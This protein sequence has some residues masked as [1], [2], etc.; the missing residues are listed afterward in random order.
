MTFFIMKKKFICTLFL[1]LI[2]C[3]PVH[4]ANPIFNMVSA[5]KS[6]KTLRQ[7]I[8]LRNTLTQML[9][10]VPTVSPNNPGAELSLSV[11]T[12]DSSPVFNL[13]VPYAPLDFQAKVLRTLSKLCTYLP[14]DKV[15]VKGEIKLGDK[16]L[17][18]PE[19]SYTL[20]DAHK[21]FLHLGHILAPSFRAV[22]VDPVGG[23]LSVSN[24]SQSKGVASQK[25]HV[26]DGNKLVDLVG[27]QGF[28]KKMFHKLTSDAAFLDNTLRYAYKSPLLEI[29][30]ET[31]HL[32]DADLQHLNQAMDRLE[33]TLESRPSSAETFILKIRP[34]S[35]TKHEKAEFLSI[36][37]L[38]LNPEVIRDLSTIL[39]FFPQNPARFILQSEE[40]NS[41]QINVSTPSTA[42]LPEILDAFYKAF[43]SWDKDL[44]HSFSTLT[45][46]LPE[47]SSKISLH[48]PDGTAALQLAQEIHNFLG[49]TG[50]E[51]I[52]FQ[53]F[54]NSTKSSIT[55]RGDYQGTFKNLVRG[56][57][58]M[59]HSR[60]SDLLSSPPNIPG[61]FMVSL[62]D[63]EGHAHFSST[64]DNTHEVRDLVHAKGWDRVKKTAA[65][66]W[67]KIKNVFKEKGEDTPPIGENSEDL[68]Q[69]L[70]R[71]E[72][73]HQGAAPMDVNT[74]YHYPEEG[75][76]QEEDEA[77]GSTETADEDQKKA[78]LEMLLRRYI[79]HGENPAAHDQHQKED[80]HAATKD[81][82]QALLKVLLQGNVAHHEAPPSS[83]I[84]STDPD[85][86]YEY[87]S[88][89]INYEYPPEEDPDAEDQIHLPNTL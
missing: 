28:F 47:H 3:G 80:N 25:F 89:D 63:D 35:R 29:D 62:I 50:T 8:E 44:D 88:E 2:I 4:A 14:H 79:S 20:S 86:N 10:T 41:T 36:Q 59:L 87:P 75:L 6:P 82:N 61:T 24:L 85:V 64:L 37:H 67:G 70:L 74:N 84:P 43:H 16:I 40:S 27:N 33:S 56:I 48:S 46:Y 60:W 71:G 54:L 69:A 39:R 12:E 11:V 7:L 1:S 9:K 31:S 49:H 81:L 22:A 13:H 53:V 58:S 42:L 76:N 18:L 73:V 51:P 66:L 26:I 5:N 45:F 15:E 77:P 32:S 55:G 83:K 38:S 68:A 34:L 72:V 65:N 78:H 17:T 19:H 30:F 21:I 57:G 52:Q 23:E